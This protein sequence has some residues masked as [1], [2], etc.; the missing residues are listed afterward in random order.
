MSSADEAA[1]QTWL[2]CPGCRYYLGEPKSGAQKCPSCGVVLGESARAAA[3]RERRR[4]KWRWILLPSSLQFGAISL[5]LGTCLVNEIRRG[6]FEVPSGGGFLLAGFGL[7]AYLFG[8]L[9]IIIEWRDLVEK[10][11]GR[12]A[13]L[14]SAACLV[15]VTLL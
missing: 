15:V 6:N 14:L 5:V 3:E 7:L 4:L 1:P 11:G 13:L 2:N 9:S 8:A 12:R 10:C